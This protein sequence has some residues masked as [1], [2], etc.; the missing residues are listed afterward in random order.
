[1]K[2]LGQIAAYVEEAPAIVI[3]EEPPVH[4]HTTTTTTTTTTPTT[5]YTTTTKVSPS[6]TVAVL[7]TTTTTRTPTTPT[8]TPTPPTTTT[9]PHTGSPQKTATER[10]PAKQIRM[11]VSTSIFIYR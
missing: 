2:K 5:T 1:M 4:T 11:A 3:N 10:Q 7:A 9:C 8:P 6:T